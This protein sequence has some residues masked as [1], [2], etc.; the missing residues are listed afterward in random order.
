[1]NDFST[2]LNNFQTIQRRAAEKQRETVARA[3]AGSRLM[4]NPTFPRKNIWM[5]LVNTSKFNYSLAS[6]TICIQF[7]PMPRAWAFFQRELMQ[8]PLFCQY[9]TGRWLQ[10][11]RT[12][13]YVRKV[14][15]LQS[16][17]ICHSQLALIICVKWCKNIDASMHCNFFFLDSISIQ[18]F[19]EID[20]FHKK[21]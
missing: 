8:T 11:W 5:Q 1:M 16:T 9:P 2:A 21:K 10:C 14:C 3:R 18:N 7:V 4:V 15:I 20:Y 13:G 12:A 17:G 6:C 19:F